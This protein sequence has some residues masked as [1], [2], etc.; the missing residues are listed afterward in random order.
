MKIR[1]R[2]SCDNQINKFGLDLIKFCKTSML[3][4]CNGRYGDDRG[5]VHFTFTGVNGNSVIDYALC[6][7]N[8]THMLQSFRV[9]ERMESSNFPINIGLIFTECTVS[10][11]KI[12]YPDYT[13]GRY[14]TNENDMRQ[15]MENVKS[16]FT[17]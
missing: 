8:I 1:K 17:N 13:M 11:D 10:T 2:E 7:N 15:Y 9:D 3:Q 14:N 5:I 4:I 16:V 12:N 6:S